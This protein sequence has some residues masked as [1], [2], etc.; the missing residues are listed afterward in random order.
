MKIIFTSLFF[1]FSVGLSALQN[2]TVSLLDF[3]P[4]IGLMKGTLTYLDYTS[5]K[6]YTMPANIILSLNK[7]KGG[8]LI[9]QFVYPDEPQ[10][11]S[12][13]TLQISGNGTLLNGGKLIERK[14]L[15]DGMLQ[16]V[17]EKSG[18]DGN[19][20]KAATLRLIYT[21][22]KRTFIIRKEVRFTGDEK[23]IKRHEYSFRR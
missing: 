20:N 18:R 16:V 11:N 19:D 6:Q 22:G 15:P 1:L 7:G 4:A 23:W 5:G 14:L 3:K 2:A 13:D 9:R 21:I 17:T 12:R 10:A 8:G